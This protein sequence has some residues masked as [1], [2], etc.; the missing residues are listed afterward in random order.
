VTGQRQQMFAHIA[1]EQ[2]AQL[3]GFHKALRELVEGHALQLLAD[4]KEDLDDPDLNE[5][6]DPV[7]TLIEAVNE[8]WG[9]YLLK[10]VLP[11]A[12]RIDEEQRQIDVWELEST[13]NHKLSAY[14]CVADTRFLDVTLHVINRY[15]VE[16]ATFTNELLEPFAQSDLS[17]I[18]R[19]KEREDYYEWLKQQAYQN[20]KNAP[21]RKRRPVQV[22]QTTKEE[23][24]AILQAVHELGLLKPQRSK[25]K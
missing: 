25:S 12:F 8:N 22:F 13:Y 18:T 6:G 21:A 4:G 23:E 7:K 10:G 20:R 2:G 11:G 9:V 3:T 19:R 14:G 17:G 5:D 1:S 16:V 24:R 15:G